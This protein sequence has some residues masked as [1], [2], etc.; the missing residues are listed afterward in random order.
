MTTE[1]RSSTGVAPTAN[2]STFTN[3]PVEAGF[4]VP[5]GVTLT[6]CAASVRP[7]TGNERVPTRGEYRSTS[8]VGDPAIATE[9]M[10][11]LGPVRPT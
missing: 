11:L 7:V 1:A 2:P 9:A 6:R 8:L 4:L 10:P 3:V 5:V